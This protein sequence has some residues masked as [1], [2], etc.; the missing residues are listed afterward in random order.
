MH[1][2]PL[3]SARSGTHWER[4]VGATIVSLLDWPTRQRE[5]LGDW[6]NSEKKGSGT[7]PRK[8]RS[9]AASRST[10]EVYSPRNDR[11][12][13]FMVRRRYFAA[14]RTAIDVYGGVGALTW[15]TTWEDLFPH[16]SLIGDKKYEPLRPFYGDIDLHADEASRL[17]PLA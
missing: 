15:E 11:R 14:V 13:Q 17:F 6:A 1:L 4:K 8:P 5:L 12:Q 7:G 10:V 2:A 3:C 16:A 9:E